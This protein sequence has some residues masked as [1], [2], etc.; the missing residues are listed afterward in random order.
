MKPIIDGYEPLRV[1]LL[2]VKARLAPDVWRLL[3]VAAT[4]KYDADIRPVVVD[5][6][7]T[8]AVVLTA[9]HYDELID[10]LH[11]LERLATGEAG[12]L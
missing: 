2:P 11:D 12:R 3:S 10:R 7:G 8:P 1:E 9:A 5:D 4:R 6:K